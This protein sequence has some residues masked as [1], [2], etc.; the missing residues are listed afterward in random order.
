MAYLDLGSFNSHTVKR[1]VVRSLSGDQGY[2][3]LV[4]VPLAFDCDGKVRSE[5]EAAIDYDARDTMTLNDLDHYEA[6]LATRVPPE[7]IH[8]REARRAALHVVRQA[9]TQVV[10]EDMFAG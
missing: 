6:V 10:F 9:L 1:D 4:G 8:E 3:S 5:I 2:S 7:T